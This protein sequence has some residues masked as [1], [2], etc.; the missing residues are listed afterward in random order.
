MAQHEN[1]SPNAS[2]RRRPLLTIGIAVVAALAA[3]GAAAL[4]VN[5]LDRRQEAKNPLSG[6]G[7]DRQY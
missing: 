6:C 2:E 1:P 5:I 3:V 4:L 7:A